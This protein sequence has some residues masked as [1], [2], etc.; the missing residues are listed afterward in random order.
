MVGWADP[1]T[2]VH[3]QETED[4]SQIRGTIFGVLS[5]Q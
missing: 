3:V 4:P 5:N 2:K 1:G